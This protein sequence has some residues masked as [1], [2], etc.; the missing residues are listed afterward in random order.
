MS[1]VQTLKPAPEWGCLLSHQ[2]YDGAHKGGYWSTYQDAVRS[3][4]ATEIKQL[5][6]NANRSLSNHSWVALNIACQKGSGMMSYPNFGGP[7]RAIQVPDVRA[8]AALAEDVGVDFRIVLMLRN[9]KR[10]V[11]S[12]L[13]RKFE[14]DHLHALKR[15]T[16]TQAFLRTQLDLLDPSFIKCWMYETPTAGISDLLPFMGSQHDPKDFQALI[17]KKYLENHISDLPDPFANRS[18]EMRT[19]FATYFDMKAK[20]CR[21]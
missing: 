17:S 7:S 5:M 20:Y 15:Y 4:S 13:K 12:G 6:I 11:Q 19:L 10:V 21:F 14:G 2:L 1:I 8:L 9:P 16:S 3:S 18:E